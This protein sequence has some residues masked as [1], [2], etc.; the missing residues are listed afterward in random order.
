[1]TEKDK[2]LLKK[3]YSKE[4]HELIRFTENEKRRFEGEMR[5]YADSFLRENFNMR[6]RI[7]IKI[8][9]RLTRSVGSFHYKSNGSGDVPKMIKISE[10]YMNC[11][12][13][14]E[15]DGIESIL[16]TLKH[17]LVHYALLE[18]GVKGYSD[19][20]VEFERKLKELNIGSSG[21]TVKSKVMS[22]KLNIWYDIYDIYRDERDNKEYR[23]NHT[24][25]AQDWIG[26]RIGVEIIKS[27]Y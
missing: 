25:K 18:Q 2:V 26:N 9:G 20:D 14:D 11:A 10:R 8:D 17:E 6:L 19:G 24:K 5:G 4:V 22:E 15:K 7:P 21:A 3:K 1:M 12:L 13:H 23:Y 16:D 27:I